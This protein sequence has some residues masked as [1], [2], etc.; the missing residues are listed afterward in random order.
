MATP[1]SA[2]TAIGS[3]KK[4]AT[5]TEPSAAETQKAYLKALDNL[6][7]KLNAGNIEE[8]KKAYVQAAQAAQDVEK[9]KGALKGTT[10]D[11]KKTVDAIGTAF[12]ANNTKAAQKAVEAAKKALELAQTSQKV[13]D[14]AV[15]NANK[16]QESLRNEALKLGRNDSKSSMFEA[17]A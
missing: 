4:T 13:A 7:K 6:S 5:P 16:S 3:V 8:A 12:R 14:D 2:V 17:L 10:K 15:A 1:I 11:I 9:A